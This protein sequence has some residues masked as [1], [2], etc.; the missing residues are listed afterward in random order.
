MLCRNLEYF[1]FCKVQTVN[2][3]SDCGITHNTQT[4]KILS[5]NPSDSVGQDKLWHPH[6]DALD[7]L[8]AGHVDCVL[9]TN[10]YQLFVSFKNFLMG[11]FH[12][13]EC[14]FMFTFFSFFFIKK[15]VFV[16][17]ISFLWWSIK[18]LQQNI[19]QPQMRIGGKKFSVEL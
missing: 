11:W 9:L 1:A 3:Y 16:S 5:S 7:N 15:C 13:K 14:Y 6:N 10:F 19:N 18:F 17:F 4:W 12:N 8:Q 2:S